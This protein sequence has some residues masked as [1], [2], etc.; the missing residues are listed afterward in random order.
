MAEKRQKT[1]DLFTNINQGA[2]EDSAGEQKGLNEGKRALMNDLFASIKDLKRGE[3][4]EV[5]RKESMAYQELLDHA[6]IDLDQQSLVQGR[7]ISIGDR[8][9]MVDF[10]FKSEGMVPRHEF[11]GEM[12]EIG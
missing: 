10:G 7:I 1:D 12:P 2:Q 4:P 9:V 5:T 8:E 11:D 3:D 6:V